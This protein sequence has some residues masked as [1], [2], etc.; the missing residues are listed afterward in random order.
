MS[1]DSTETPSDPILGEVPRSVWAAASARARAVYGRI[2]GR[3]RG[4]LNFIATSLLSRGVSITCQ[5]LQVPVALHYLGDEAFGLWITFSG[6]S[7]LLTVADF[8]VGLGAQ[9]Q[10]AEASAVG[11]Q[12]QA[13]R[14]FLTAAGALLALALALGVVVV[15]VC[16]TVDWAHLLKLSDPRTVGE[17]HRAAALVAVLCCAGIA[18]SMGTRLAFA[19]QLGWLN[20]LQTSVANLLSLAGIFFAS[21]ADLGI[22]GLFAAVFLPGVV[23]NLVLLVSLVRR[24][25]WFERGHG[26]F[27]SRDA[28]DPAAL[29]ELLSVGSLFFVQQVCDIS[30]YTAPALLISA[31]LGAATVTPFNIGQRLFS[32]F[33][34]VQNAFL[35]PLWPAYAEAKAKGDW[36]WVRRT[37][38]LSV[39]ASLVLTILPM[40][41]ASVFGADVLRLWIGRKTDAAS[42]PGAPLLWLLFAW[43]AVVVFQQPYAFLLS[44]MSEVRRLSLYRIVTAV[45]AI[46]L[47]LLCGPRFGLPGIVAA[48]IGA[49]LVSLLGGVL[50]TRRFL[51]GL[52]STDAARSLPSP[53][54]SPLSP[55]VAP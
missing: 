5:L 15:P 30:L 24:A 1:P 51:H 55:A 49:M 8:G 40:S 28:F 31:L 19:L 50:E 39:W 16:L 41:V 46:A 45:G 34:V 47:M 12:R 32:L 23:L 13:R 42:L 9:N 10:I 21:R 6:F 54:D 29:R 2:S 48:L 36:A 52:T 11:D 18:T 37:L 14:V 17:V 53:P 35:P 26:R 4:I 20:N 7:T 38:R 43:N 22:L 44:G 25:G 3:N 33:L 27:F